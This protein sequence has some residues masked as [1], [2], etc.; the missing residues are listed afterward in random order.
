MSSIQYQSIY[1]AFRSNENGKTTFGIESHLTPA[2]LKYLNSMTQGYPPFTVYHPRSH[3]RFLI[4]C[5][6]PKGSVTCNVKTNEELEGL[7]DKSRYAYTRHMDLLYSTDADKNNKNRLAYTITFKMGILKGKTPADI[8]Y[9]VENGPEQLER[10][11]AFLSENIE[12]YPNNKIY[13]DAINDILQ[14]PG[15]KG[16]IPISIPI[17]KFYK[18]ADRNSYGTE[19]MVN[20]MTAVWNLGTENPIELSISNF[21]FDPASQTTFN[22]RMYSMQL[23]AEEWM[24]CIRRIETNMKMFELRNLKSMFDEVEEYMQQ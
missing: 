4:T 17:C 1:A 15:D 16:S 10:Q 18:S 8:Y 5:T 24:L 9:N 7:I 22:R 14:N 2:R 19:N 11:R 3:F 13:L 23:T 12:K 20:T 21:E 6:N